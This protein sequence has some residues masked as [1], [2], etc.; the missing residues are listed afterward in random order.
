MSQAHTDN[1]QNRRG[2]PAAQW[3]Q[4]H[5]VSFLITVKQIGSVGL[6]CFFSFGACFYLTVSHIFTRDRED[7]KGSVPQTS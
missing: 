7:I 3:I 2:N 6:S 4:V 1:L 5:G